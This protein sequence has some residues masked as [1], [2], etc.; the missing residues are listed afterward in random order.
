MTAEKTVED[1]WAELGNDLGT[2]VAADLV[3]IVRRYEAGA[4][5]SQ[6]HAI[7][8]S[9][10]G[11]PC[12]RCLA[13]QVLGVPVRVGGDDPWARIIGTAV[14]AWLDEAMVAECKRLN[15]GRWLAELRVYPDPSLV[16]LPKGGRADL[17]DTDRRMVIDHKVVGIPSL[18]KYR[19]N[20]PGD[21]Y[22]YQGHLYGMGCVNQ[23]K[24]VEHVAIACWPRGGRLS[25]LWV[26]TEPYSPAKAQAALDRFATIRD[27]ALTTGPAIIPLLPADP[28]CWDCEGRDDL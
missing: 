14:H 3:D 26:W 16:L 19:A 18:R 6:Q 12:T 13:R 25:E 17:Y 1:V 7:G 5:R 20:G 8:P 11:S 4:E 15:R 2:A 10:I 22:T 9:A 23:G 28:D 21:Q 27:L 24:P